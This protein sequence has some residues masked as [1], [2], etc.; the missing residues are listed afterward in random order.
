N[1]ECVKEAVELLHLDRVTLASASFELTPVGGGAKRAMTLPE[2]TYEPLHKGQTA[3]KMAEEA[4]GHPLGREMAHGGM[5]RIYGDPTDPNSVL[6]VY[7]PSLQRGMT[8]EKIAGLLQRELGWE[9]FLR[10]QGLPMAEI[11]RSPAAQALWR[12][13]IIRMKKIKGGSLW[14]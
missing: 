1:P 2:V 12:K 10:E 13:G 3:E 11:D 14:N 8:P 4:V 6:K 5:R 9:Q 7:D